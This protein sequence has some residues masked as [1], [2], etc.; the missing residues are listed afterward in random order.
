MPRLATS[1]TFQRVPRTAAT[2]AA[3]GLGV[4]ALCLVVFG[5]SQKLLQL[6]VLLG[7]WSAL[8]AA[9]RIFGAG[10]GRPDNLAEAE[11]AEARS[12]AAELHRA[13]LKVVAAQQEQLEAARQ[14]GFSQEIE[15]RQ[16]GELQ[17]A[18]EAAARRASELELEISLRREIERVLS[19]QLGSLREEVAALRAEVV[20][21]LGGQLRLERIETTR[22]I[23]SDLEALQHE[24]RRLAAAKQESLAAPVRTLD[25]SPAQPS[26]QRPTEVLGAEL[27][28][29]PPAPAAEPPAAGVRGVPSPAGEPPAAE[30]S[31][32]SEAQLAIERQA[33]RR[34]APDPEPMPAQRYQGR[35]RADGE[36]A[37]R[38]ARLDT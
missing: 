35:R 14:A 4:A 13:Q 31:K 25:L 19:E 22:V 10:H 18:R 29:F 27:V 36:Q 3:A 6:G 28:E 12:Q 30:P 17:F 1:W 16:F 7:L 23:G 8:I 24:I 9:F 37:D 26:R 38:F 32:A 11:L 5:T 21:K 15:L 34:R 33:G 2:A 20:D